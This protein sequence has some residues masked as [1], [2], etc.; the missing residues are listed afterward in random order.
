MPL[1][2]CLSMLCGIDKL[3][4]FLLI[5][6]WVGGREENGYSPVFFLTALLPP[7]LFTLPFGKN[8]GFFY[9][10]AVVCFS[11]HGDFVFVDL[12][13]LRKLAYRHHFD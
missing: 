5:T 9:V 2:V 12:C 10:V 11:P 4:L 1:F 8:G 7:T 6:E 13:T 3:F